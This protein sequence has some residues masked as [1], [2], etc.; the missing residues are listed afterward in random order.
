MP[1]P[2]KWRSNPRAK[3]FIRIIEMAAKEHGIDP[4]LL[5]SIIERESQFDPA[6]QSPAGA[7]GIAQLVG[8]FHP[9]VDVA[10]PVASIREAA[11]YM[12]ANLKRFNGDEGQAL[13]AYNHGPTAVRSY[14]NDWRERIPPETANYVA[15]LLRK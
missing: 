10:D 12:K 11:K 7:A 1:Q 3:D 6:A 5:G 14:G 15:A 13:A 8:K 2:P 9:G 4:D